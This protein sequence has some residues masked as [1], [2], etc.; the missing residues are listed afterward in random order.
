MNSPRCIAAQNGCTTSETIRVLN[1]IATLQS[2][3]VATTARTQGTL[4]ATSLGPSSSRIGVE[5]G[6]LARGVRP[7]RDCRMFVDPVAQQTWPEASAST[8]PLAA[9]V[10][11]PDAHLW[12]REGFRAGLMTGPAFALA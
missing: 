4:T 3:R 8:R 10:L 7:G 12:R 5:S 1:S 2:V 6:R 11:A 9:S